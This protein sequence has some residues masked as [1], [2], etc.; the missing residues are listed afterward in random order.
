MFSGLS[1]ICGL[2]LIVDCI[3]A[4]PANVSDV[5]D[6][7]S[8]QELLNLERAERLRL[9]TE[10]DSLSE[11]FST[12]ESNFHMQRDRGKYQTFQF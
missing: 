4:A 6:V 9:Q 5:G 12:L 1:V 3:L 2:C 11:K 8:L 10:L 7:K